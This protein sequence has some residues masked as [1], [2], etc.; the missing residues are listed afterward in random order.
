MSKYSVEEYGML[1]GHFTQEKRQNVT[2]KVVDR[3]K[4]GKMNR[5]E[6]LVDRMIVERK[7]PFDEAMAMKFP[8]SSKKQ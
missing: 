8:S 6:P 7:I 2:Q 1:Y 5:K 3:T 4:D